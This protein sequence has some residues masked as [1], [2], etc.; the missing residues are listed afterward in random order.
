MLYFVVSILDIGDKE[1]KSDYVLIEVYLCIK[2]TRVSLYW[3]VSS[4]GVLVTYLLLWQNLIK[5]I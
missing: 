5:A 4:H 3:L 1:D 2:K